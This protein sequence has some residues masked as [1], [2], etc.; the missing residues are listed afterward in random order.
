LKK[1]KT[2]KI[3]AEEIRVYQTLKKKIEDNYKNKIPLIKARAGSVMEETPSFEIGR[4][5]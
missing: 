5:E 2:N 1:E 3:I 4:E